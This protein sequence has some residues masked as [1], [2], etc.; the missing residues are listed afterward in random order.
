MQA[1]L[2]YDRLSSSYDMLYGEEQRE[3]YEEI[4]RHAVGKELGII[5]DIG[6]GTALLLEYL[7][8]NHGHEFTYYIGVD[9]SVGMLRV[10]K[11]RRGAE[12]DLIQ[13][14]AHNIPLREKS[15]DKTLAIT[16]IHHLDEKKALEEIRRV[17]RE[18]AIITY[19][20]R[21]TKKQETV[22]KH[23]AKDVI[24]IVRG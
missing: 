6:C 3:K 4:F 22:D 8:N 11:R 23:G 24:I 19:H 14:D 18:E 2:D 17:T 21:I 15:I 9:K 12:A 20:K 16:V 7:R 10:A 1:Y 13:A 5:L